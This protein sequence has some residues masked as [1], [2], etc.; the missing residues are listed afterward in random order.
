MKK[1]IFIIIQFI[2]II[3]TGCNNQIDQN[4]S[5]NNMKSIN[6]PNR[7]IED[8]EKEVFNGDTSSY[9][10]LRNIYLDQDPGDFLFWALLMSNK[11]SYPNAYY[12][13]FL[14]IVNSYVGDIE[15]INNIDPITKKLAI[16]Y[17]QEAVNNNVIEAKVD[18]NK[19]I[20][21]GNL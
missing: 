11:H 17:L 1:K 2:I 16:E 21:S 7:E 20:E 9:I 18:L 5:P 13:V 3:I 10:E 12:D 15:R 4:N 6:S 14:C 8:I 19:I